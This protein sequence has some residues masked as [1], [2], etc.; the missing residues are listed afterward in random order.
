MSV[1][2]GDPLLIAEHGASAKK[3]IANYSIA[4]ATDSTIAA[5]ISVTGAQ[6]NACAV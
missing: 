4:A 3:L 1:Y 2:A 5:V 6:A